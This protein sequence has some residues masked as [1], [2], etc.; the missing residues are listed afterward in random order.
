MA[1]SRH[2]ARIALMQA[3]FNAEF[4][5]MD[6]DKSA[7]QL[8]Q[9]NVERFDLRPTEKNWDF[10]RHLIK[11]MGQS[12]KKIEKDIE[13]FAPERPV[14]QINAIDRLLLYIGIFEIKYDKGKE[15]TPAVVVINEAV[16]IAKE[17]GTESG[18][19][20]INGVLHNIYQSIEKK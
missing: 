8:V 4:R 18:A 19:K 12:K 11:G 13:D 6:W 17:Y 15:K 3:L 2:M 20:F 9:E 16:E 10:I 5:D 1:I 7:E 14:D